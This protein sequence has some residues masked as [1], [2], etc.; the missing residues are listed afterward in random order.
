MNNYDIRIL[1]QS[2]SNIEK[3]IDILKRYLNL[4]LTT[5]DSTREIYDNTVTHND[6]DS[7]VIIITE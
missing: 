2:I 5:T 6:D 3:E 1:K 7:A 4:S